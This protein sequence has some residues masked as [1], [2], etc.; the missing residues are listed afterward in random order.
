MYPWTEVSVTEHTRGTLCTCPCISST[1]R[2]PDAEFM[3]VWFF[4]L[5]KTVNPPATKASAA[6][7]SLRVCNEGDYVKTQ[8]YASLSVDVSPS[9]ANQPIELHWDRRI[10]R[11]LRFITSPIIVSRQPA[12]S[13]DEPVMRV[14]RCVYATRYHAKACNRPACP[15]EWI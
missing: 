4:Y 8:M 10:S 6:Y 11:A 9:K 2:S 13:E 3:F 7:P 14:F 15:R 12:G 5:F 1:R